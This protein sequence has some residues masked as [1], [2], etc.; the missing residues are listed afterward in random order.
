MSTGATT[1]CPVVGAPTNT[2]YCC[3]TYAIPHI[4][5]PQCVWCTTSASTEPG[6]ANFKYRE[7]PASELNNP[8]AKAKGGQNTMKW[9]AWEVR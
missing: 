4:D 6:G 8:Y 2:P 5:T 9:C 3:D 1:R 7:A